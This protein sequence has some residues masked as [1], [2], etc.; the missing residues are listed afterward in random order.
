VGCRAGGFPALQRVGLQLRFARRAGPDIDSAVL[1]GRVQPGTRQTAELRLKTCVGEYAPS[2]IDQGAVGAPL[3][4]A[5][6]GWGKIVVTD[7]QGSRRLGRGNAGPRQSRCNRY[8][9]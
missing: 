9:E 5:V 8:P 2:E 7:G 1:Q 3:G 4:I 6:D